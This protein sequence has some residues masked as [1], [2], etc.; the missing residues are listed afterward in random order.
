[1]EVLDVILQELLFDLRVT[2]GLDLEKLLTRNVHCRLGQFTRL[3]QQ[4]DPVGILAVVDFDHLHHSI[5]TVTRNNLS[6]AAGDDT[7]DFGKDTAHCINSLQRNRDM[8]REEFGEQT[9]DDQTSFP[10]ALDTILDLIELGGHQSIQLNQFLG[11]NLVFNQ[12][13]IELSLVV[14]AKVLESFHD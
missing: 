8:T 10:S 2:Q 6:I 14:L 11:R 13:T 1:L 5:E 7:E 9:L 4:L 3:T 12:E